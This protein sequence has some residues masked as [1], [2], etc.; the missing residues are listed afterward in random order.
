[1]PTSATPESTELLHYAAGLVHRRSSV[2]AE[3]ALSRLLSQSMYY[4]DPVLAPPMLREAVHT[5]MEIAVGAMAS[6]AR[7]T[8]SGEYAWHLGGVRAGHGFP[9]EGLVHAFRIAN[10]TAW[11]QLVDAV[12]REV[13]ESAQL[14]LHA[15]PMVWG[16][17]HRDTLIVTEAHRQTT[18]GRPG[19]E[20][21]LVKP[22]LDFL[23][24]GSSDQ[25][26]VSGAAVLLDLP[27]E[28]RYAVA[29]VRGGVPSGRELTVLDD[30]ATGM[31]VLRCPTPDGWVVL[32]SLAERSLDDLF[33][34][35]PLPRGA[36]CGIS[37]VVTGL[38]ELGR[39]RHFADLALGTCTG[40]G[41]TARF[42]RRMPEG[43]MVSRPDLAAELVEQVLGPV[44]GLGEPD[45]SV[46]LE[47]LAV[48]LDCGGSVVR[49]G[50][51]L[52]CHRNT[53]Q[54]RLRRL[55]QLTGR[56]FSR[57]RDVVELALALDAYRIQQAA[58]REG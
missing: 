33:A 35:L 1:M 10:T 56:Q 2:L 57:P 58:A 41:E 7:F 20:S 51:Q 21:R 5:G 19:D 52:F 25:L 50:K 40:E 49:V 47:T 9:V 24:R 6:P 28:G 17:C 38:S 30:A 16:Y 37:P 18:E 8:D 26:A 13:P 53:I 39:A 44:R 42:D 48:W 43:I 36:R 31:R 12:S 23:L 55:E 32:A 3:L 14:L 46:L 34:L 22:L 45:K 27:M 29:R 54:N 15:A 11:E 4:T